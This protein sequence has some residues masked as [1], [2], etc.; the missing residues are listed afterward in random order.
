MK[1]NTRSLFAPSRRA[2]FVLLLGT[3]LT[4]EPF[5]AHAQTCTPTPPN[6]VAWFPGDGNAHDISGQNNFGVE[7]T[8][9]AYAAGKVGPAFQFN[10]TVASVVTISDSQS[11]RPLNAITIDAWINPSSA[12]TGF[13][14]VLFKGSTGS[15][16]GQP[17]SLFVSGPSHQIVVRIGNDSTFEAVGSNAG[18]PTGVYTHV[19]A[20]YDGTTIRIYINGTLDVSQASAI[21]TLAQANTQPLYLGGVAGSNHFNGAAD[22]I[23]IFSRALSQSEIQAIV[24]A[25]SAG[26][27][28]PA[29]PP[30]ATECTPPPSGMAAWLTGDGTGLDVSGNNNNGVLGT[31][32]TFAAGVVGQAF[33]FDATNGN[34][35]VVTVPDSPSLHITTALTID[36]WIKPTGGI[37][38]VLKGNFGG[39]GDQP[40]GL[41]LGNTTATETQIILSLGNNS[42][43]D[44]LSSGS[45]IPLN[46][47]THVTGTYDGTT[48]RIYINGLLDMVKTTNIGMLNTNDTAPL[49]I[50]AGV[51]GTYTGAVDELEIFNRALSD[52]EVYGI[53]NAGSF[54]KCKPPQLVAA[55]SRKTHGGAGTFDIDLPLTGQLAVEG[56]STS[57]NHSFVFTF[58]HNLVGGTAAVTSGIGNTAGSPTFAGNTMTVNVAGVA[59]VQKIKLTLSN[60]QDTTMRVL[61]SAALNI[62]ILAGD[63]N[64]NGSVSATDVGQVKAL[65]GASA[66]AANFRADINANGT[67]NATDVGQVKASSGHVLP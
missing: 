29:L 20:T 23:E 31:Q 12:S 17:Y 67:I 24:N 10:G 25:G 52:S 33:Q 55:A 50:G 38:V 37:D 48:M 28:K 14:G 36:A 30:P 63:S 62:G 4:A 54:G 59:D 56:R 19:A 64:G 44:R 7:G 16:G 57:G 40:Y 34:A 6:L 3:S 51:S 13:E 1:T 35:S 22:E 27:C 39:P 58:D 9:T 49:R 42:T 41:L 65:A 60:V 21:G 26:H 53:F 18:I 45:Y 61:P 47:W 32:T 43:F 66:T 2:F 11:L 15:A 5:L 8:G 46:S